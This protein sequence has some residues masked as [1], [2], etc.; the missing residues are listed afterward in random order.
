[1]DS[2]LIVK[3]QS[4]YLSENSSTEQR[5]TSVDIAEMTSLAL[6][7]VYCTL[8]QQDLESFELSVG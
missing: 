6:D 7:Y 3:V 2:V 8:F 1:M 5:N 4:I